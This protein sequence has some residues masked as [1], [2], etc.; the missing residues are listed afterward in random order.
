MLTPII[1]MDCT[2]QLLYQID[3]EF[4]MSL[5]GQFIELETGVKYLKTY[6]NETT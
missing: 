6:P 2:L 1:Y 5:K 3:E 4:V